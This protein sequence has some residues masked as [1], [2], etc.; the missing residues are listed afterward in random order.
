MFSRPPPAITAE[1]HE[2]LLTLSVEEALFP[3]GTP[4]TKD[5]FSPAAFKNLQTQA[6]GLLT[7][8]QN[9]YR[10]K[11]QAL[12]DL[13]KDREAEREEVEEA[14]TRAKHLKFQLEDMASKATEQER[15]MQQLMEELAVERRG[16]RGAGAGVQPP[17]HHHEVHV[18]GA[19]AVAVARRVPVR[20]R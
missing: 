11:A 16:P 6:T 1:M 4:A 12:V 3:T 10:Q 8:M 7:K 14:E 2:E 13:E 19:P 17:G 5:A 18:A 9:A 20:G 15:R